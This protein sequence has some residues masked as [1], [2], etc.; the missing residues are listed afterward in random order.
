MVH[1][2][3]VFR[4]S[5]EEN[6]NVYSD[7]IQYGYRACELGRTTLNPYALVVMLAWPHHVTNPTAMKYHTMYCTVRL[8]GIGT[9]I[10]EASK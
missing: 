9:G 7:T 4:V 2:R 1:D 3:N 5:G 8:R 10:S 6:A